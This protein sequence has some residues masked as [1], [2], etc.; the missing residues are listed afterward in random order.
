MFQTINSHRN[1]C[2]SSS[3]CMRV[4][5]QTHWGIA[6]FILVTLGDCCSHGSLTVT[7]TSSSP[8]GH[9][10][11]PSM[12]PV[13]GRTHRLQVGARLAWVWGHSVVLLILQKSER[14]KT[15]NKQETSLRC[16]LAR[17]PWRGAAWGG[18]RCGWWLWCASACAPPWRCYRPLWF[19]FF[20]TRTLNAQE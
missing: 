6:T 9:G 11:Y 4:H 5:T 19:F 15:N 1:P 13:H 20:A 8:A 2:R 14:R 12:A 17:Q 10:S 18:V 16:A 7:Y 3:M